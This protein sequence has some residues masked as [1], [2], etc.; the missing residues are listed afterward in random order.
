MLHPDFR[1][2]MLLRNRQDKN[3]IPN[4]GEVGR[5]GDT[6]ASATRSRTSPVLCCYRHTARLF[7][8]DTQVKMKVQC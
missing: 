7:R 1:A 2:V 8:H 6:A 4:H 3:W 5:E